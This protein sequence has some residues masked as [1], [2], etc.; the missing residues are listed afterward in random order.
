LNTTV[1][2]IEGRNPERRLA[3][4]EK[5]SYSQG[6]AVSTE[7]VVKNPYITLYCL[8]DKN[9][10]AIFVETP[11]EV[12]IY[13][14][15]FFYQA[16]YEH[17]TQLVS[18]PYEQLISISKALKPPKPLIMLYSL[19]RCGSTLLSHCFNK[20][21][22]T[23]SVSE[24]DVFT[25]I[26]GLREVDLSR[27]AELK[28]LARACSNLLCKTSPN[29]EVS[30][31]AF[32]FRGFCIETADL[33]HKALPQAKNLF[34]YRN[35]EG[36][37]QS[38]ARL[39]KLLD[40][41]NDSLVKKEINPNMFATYPRVN[42]ISYL[43]KLEPLPKL[44]RLE[45]FAL[46]WLSMMNRYLEHIEAGIPFAALRYEDLIQES[47]TML[48]KVFAYSGLTEA[49]VSKALKAFSKDSQEGTRFSGIANRMD[50]TLELTENHLEQVRAV[51]NI[52]PVLNQPDV[53]LPNTL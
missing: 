50:K 10:R 3:S 32:K 28:E 13:D 1:L 16:Q 6:S 14:A 29:K 22:N 43:R 45:E 26:T 48:K 34:L 21:D 52:H 27:D 12:A 25:H 18:V 31:Y 2:N 40:P 47:E 23:L 11:K 36:W 37:M 17:A 4:L 42:F 30:I 39:T 7:L 35:L 15:P 20:L 24:P 41:A 49:D 46:S 5:F 44:S 53:I 9:R 19:G 8:D 38:M 33:I 51:L